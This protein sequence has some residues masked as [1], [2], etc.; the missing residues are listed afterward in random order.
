MPDG[1]SEIDFQDSWQTEIAAYIVD[2]VIGL[3]MV[4]A[5]VQRKVDGR[6][7]QCSG[8]SSR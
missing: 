5:T 6:M 8:S 2:R 1:T 3:E 4:P 7:V